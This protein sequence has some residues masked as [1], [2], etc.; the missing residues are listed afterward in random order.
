MSC[1]MPAS[2]MADARRHG[3]HRD[4]VLQ[5][6]SRKASAIRARLP[7][8][9]RFKFGPSRSFAAAE[10]K[11]ANSQYNPRAREFLHHLLCRL[12]SPSRAMA[13]RASRP[14]RFIKLI[15]Q[16]PF[17][18]QKCTRLRINRRDQLLPEDFEATSR[19]RSAPRRSSSSRLWQRN[20]KDIDFSNPFPNLLKLPAR[21]KRW[22]VGT[23][24]IR[25]RP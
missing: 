1:G 16:G 2:G 18:A 13:R 20:K 24:P 25:N 15:D 7:A 6:T 4:H 8:M 22:M 10:P 19:N 21:P 9:G 23:R 3:V 11:E 12:R 17:T 5:G 14:V